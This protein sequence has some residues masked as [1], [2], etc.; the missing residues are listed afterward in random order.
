MG[1]LAFNKGYALD[2]PYPGY[3]I[4]ARR[5]KEWVNKLTELKNIHSE[6]CTDLKK[7]ADK[8]LDTLDNKIISEHK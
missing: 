3:G 8:I 7:G 4:Y 1:V 2:D 5:L 6:F